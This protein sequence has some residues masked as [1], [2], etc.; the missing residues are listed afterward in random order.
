MF[1]RL[2]LIAAM[3]AACKPADTDAEVA[4]GKGLEAVAL[5]A[6]DEAT[7]HDAAIRAAFD[8]GPGLA[9]YLHPHRLPRT[10][11]YDGGA[12]VAASLASALR[13]KGAVKGTC[14]PTRDAP[15]SPP[16]CDVPEPG[17]LIR[18][19]DVLRV[20]SDTLQI[21]FAAER[22]AT[23]DGPLQPPFQ[24]EKIYQ[25]IPDGSGW[26]VVREARVTEDKS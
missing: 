21:H 12:A 22:F 23:R 4:R 26:R 18:T 13:S 17:Y 20:S 2:M 9:L 7:V 15:A 19:S 3:T 16:R 14:D 6:K 10:A 1:R 24:F 8:V 5:P 25:L 11:G